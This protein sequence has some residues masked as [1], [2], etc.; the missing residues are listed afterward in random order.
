MKLKMKQIAPAFTL[1]LCGLLVGC[2]TGTGGNSSGTGAAPQAPK[3][4]GRIMGGQQPIS[5]ASVQLFTPN[6]NT[7]RGAA[8]PLGPAVTTDANGNFDLTG[9]YICISDVPVY[10]SATLGDPGLGTGTNGAIAEMAVLPSC[11]TL[12]ANAAN[13]FINVNEVTTAA[14]IY[15]LAP[16]MSDLQHVGAPA[17][18]QT[19]LLNAMQMAGVLAN[20][21]TGTTPGPNLAA[22]ASFS[23]ATINTL[24]DIIAACINSNGDTSTTGAPCNTFFTN[25]TIAGLGFSPQDTVTATVN[26]VTHPASN[27]SALYGLVGS[28]LPFQPTL[29]SAPIDWTLPI[30][31]TGGGLKTPYGIAID[32]S[33]NAWVT[34]ESG[35]SVTEFGLGGNVIS[36]ANGF[37]GNGNIL[38]AKAIAFD[39]SG[40]AW[41]ASTAGNSI[42]KL[43][44]D[45]SFAANYTSGIDGP[46]AIA[47]NSAGNVWVANFAGNTVTVLNSS[48][49]TIDGSPLTDG[50]VVNQ[51]VA[52]A[53]DASGNAWVANTGTETLLKFGSTGTLLS[54]SGNGYTDG[55][56]GE[57]VSMD[58]DSSGNVWLTENALNN[59]NSLTPSGT[60]ESSTAIS[61]LSGP[62]GLAVDGA[63]VVW[64][65]NAIAGSSLTQFVPGSL[66]ASFYGTL[67]T[68]IGVAVDGSG[69][70][71][72]TDSGD[73]SVTE[74]VGIATPV[75]TPKV[76]RSGP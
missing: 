33:G 58:F 67:S 72:T 39:S 20:T 30:K 28:T 38:G 31:Y 29:V 61:G 76:T 45:G 64:A 53:I 55:N 60:T 13:I 11:L 62:R 70:V 37:T 25:T 5:G 54:S 21:S 49:N 18:L 15:A 2:G 68:P 52:I 50:V 3:F 56:L 4:T 65:T 74:F 8:S 43:N 24:A 26:L 73:N 35:S 32:T 42:V 22:N 7:L 36:G 75:T 71:W 1:V 16:F 23:I 41:V 48:G 57:P 46:A 17:N 40:S 63:N 44:T 47:V 12:Q 6:T 10:L 19:G 34:N 66:L 51:P 9:R 27:V 59:I 69:N 14:A